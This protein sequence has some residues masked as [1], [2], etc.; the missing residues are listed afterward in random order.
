[1]DNKTTKKAIRYLRFSNDGQSSSSI[2][3][4]DII[5]S[6]WCL[7]N[8]VDISDTF[9]DEG[10]SARTFDPPDVK[11]LFEFIRLNHREINYLV[12]SELTRFSRELG[13][14]VTTVKKISG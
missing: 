3:R 2:E 13:E 11:K 6:N 7:K 5:T 4:Q 12:V 10:H 14:A 9:I 1:M 8:D